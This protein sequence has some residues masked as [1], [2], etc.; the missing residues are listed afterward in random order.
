[1][2]APHAGT[3]VDAWMTLMRTSVNV[4]L[5]SGD[6]T[7]TLVCVSCSVGMLSMFDYCQNVDLVSNYAQ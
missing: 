1:M 4:K 3:V 2:Q 5:V 7:V 6:T